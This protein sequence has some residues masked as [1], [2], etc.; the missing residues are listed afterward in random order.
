AGNSV[1][2]NVSV[3]N[4]PSNQGVKFTISPASQAANLTVQDPFD[5]IYNAPTTPPASD[6]TVTVTATSVEDS[7]KTS[8]VIIT[9]PSATIAVTPATATVDATGTVPNLIATV[10]NDPSNKGVTWT[11]ACAT[12]ACGSVPPGPTLSGNATTYTAPSTPPSP[13]DL[14]VT[15]TAQSVADP[16]AQTSMTVTVKAI[17]VVVTA[18]SG[19][20]QFNQSVANI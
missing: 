20:V 2:M 3:N 1:P 4:D 9:V 13:G 15:I 12:T 7:T 10:S 5:A 14:T 8:T 6:L 11:V 18:P 16:A 19:T 17:S